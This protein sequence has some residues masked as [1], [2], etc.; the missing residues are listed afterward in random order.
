MDKGLIDILKPSSIASNNSAS[1]ISFFHTNANFSRTKQTFPEQDNGPKMAIKKTGFW[2]HFHRFSPPSQFLCQVIWIHW[3]N[4]RPTWLRS[5]FEWRRNWTKL[6]MLKILI[7]SY[8]LL[9]FA[10]GRT[11]PEDEEDSFE[12]VQT[13]FHSSKMACR[14][15]AT[16][17]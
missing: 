6:K 3:K 8:F 11:L 5:K 13:V 1:Q 4:L 2:L 16:I 9:S 14:V 17:L 10:D 12:E 15:Q 7:I